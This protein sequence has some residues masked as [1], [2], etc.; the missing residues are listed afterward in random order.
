M[1]I[2]HTRPKSI[3][4]CASLSL[5]C[6][7]RYL[8]PPAAPSRVVPLV[9]S[10][11]PPPREGEGRVTLD[12]PDGPARAEL[13]TQRTQIA[14]A[15]GGAF[16]GHHGHA[17]YVPSTQYTLRPLCETPCAVNLPLGTHEILFT[18]VNPSSD[19]S[20]TT[21]LNVGVAPSIVRHAIGRQVSSVGALVGGIVMTSVGVVL[22]LVGGVLLAAP[23]NRDSRV[24]DTSVAGWA[25]LGVGLGLAASGVVLGQLGRPVEQP[26]ATTHWTP[27]P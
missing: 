16:V 2:P 26:G 19:R 5:G 23:D 18:S 14:G 21:Y 15:R 17:A 22:S 24:V 4:L 1:I 13:I 25:S 3:L 8:P 12:T 10:R 7:T 11:P 9:E 6:A 20:S 27:G